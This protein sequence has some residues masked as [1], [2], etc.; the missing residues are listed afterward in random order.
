M[1]I[2]IRNFKNILKSGTMNY[3]IDTIHLCFDDD[4]RVVSKMI[5]NARDIIVIIDT[6]NDIIPDLGDT[7]FYFDEPALQLR[8][9]LNLIEDDDEDADIKIY[10]EKVVIKQGDAHVSAFFCVPQSVGIFN[11]DAPTDVENFLTMDVTDDFMS[12]FSKISK[13]GSRFGKVYFN[14][15][16]GQFSIETS[17]KTNAFSNGLEF[18]LSTNKIDSE[19]LTLCFDYRNM[20]N[21]MSIIDNE[22]IANFAYLKDKELGM[23][24]VTSPDLDYRYYLMSREV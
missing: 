14:V 9:F 24:S 13:I 7:D 22:Y 23:M 3:S 8:P 5:G 10:Q 15:K 20:V 6:V 2:N 21:L 12:T 18:D 4:N 11:S 16:D 19:D 17:D 1:E